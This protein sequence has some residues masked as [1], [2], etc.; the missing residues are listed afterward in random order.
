MENYEL[1]AQE[2]ALM[3]AKHQQIL[4]ENQAKMKAFF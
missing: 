1:S 4:K 2:L 3:K